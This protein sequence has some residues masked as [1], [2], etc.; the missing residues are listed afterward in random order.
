MASQVQVRD[1][2]S[3]QAYG[4]QLTR[5][6]EE[7]LDSASKLSALAEKVST[8]AAGIR[9]ATSSQESNWF[10]PQYTSLK[11]DLD[12]VVDSVATTAD[13]MRDTAQLVTTKME[14]VQGSIDY[15]ALLVGKLRDV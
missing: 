1:V 2:D 9:S 12:P 10:D 4:A 6:R 3:L 5:L 8:T 15:I 13:S 14:S 7:L 11:G